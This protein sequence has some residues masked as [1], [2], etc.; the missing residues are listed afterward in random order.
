[1]A[2][3]EH[4]LTYRTVF[5]RV[6]EYYNGILFLT[7]NR[8]GTLDEAFKSRIHMSLYYPPLGR[9]Q[10]QAIWKMNLERLKSIEE[11]RR[12]ATGE[13]PL[14]IYEKEILDFAAH[15]YERNSHGRGRWNG[16]QI[17]NAFQIASSLARH[18]LQSASGK[19]L[20][21]DPEP[22]LIRPELRAT[23]FETVAYATLEFD[24]YMNETVGK[25]DAELAFELSNRADHND[26][27]LSAYRDDPVGDGQGSASSYQGS[28]GSINR[29]AK[30][31]GYQQRPTMGQN[32][33][34]MRASSTMNVS[35]ESPPPL[36]AKVPN[37]DF[38]YSNK[39]YTPVEYWSRK[40]YPVDDSDGF[41]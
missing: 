32:A 35:H 15:H 10:T 3:N 20:E 4:R 40:D 36:R 34:E 38:S 26:G 11:Q 33:Q 7:T 1:L 13:H 9:T 25:T 12:Q 41:E 39:N 22:S 5:L 17:R 29:L 16:R 19:Q 27:Y 30:N 14:V 23:R 6:L 18:D 21:S 24:R 2:Y 28:P 8:V 31:S 37:A